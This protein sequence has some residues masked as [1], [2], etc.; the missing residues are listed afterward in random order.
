MNGFPLRIVSVALFVGAFAGCGM[1][2]TPPNQSTRSAEA[3]QG[4]T[5][6]RTEIE[7]TNQTDAY[8]VIRQLRPQW[9]RVRGVHSLRN[10]NPVWVYV[11]RSRVGDLSALRQITAGSI[12]SIIY[13]SGPDA[14][15][16]WGLDHVNGA[17]EIVSRTGL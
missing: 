14:S 16:R 1:R 3:R 17:I 5:I 8:G 7:A 10:Q 11:D 6:E 15:Q 4:R 13:H 9:L 12:E 2:T